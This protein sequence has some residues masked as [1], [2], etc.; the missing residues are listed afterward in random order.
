MPGGMAERVPPQQQAM[1]SVEQQAMDSAEQQAQ[2]METNWAFP[3]Q[4]ASSQ[5]ILFKVYFSLIEFILIITAEIDY[6]NKSVVKNYVLLIGAQ[7]VAKNNVSSF[8]SN[9]F[10]YIS[11]QYTFI[12][13]TYHYIQ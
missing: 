12:R 10:N 6:W 3:F 7:L 1:D 13:A 9:H 2:N 11:L 4:L 8:W 5:S